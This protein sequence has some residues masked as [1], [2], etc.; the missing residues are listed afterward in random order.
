MQCAS[1]QFENMPGIEVCG[2]CGSPLG[3]QTLAIDVHPPRAG[4]RTKQWRRRWSPFRSLYYKARE[5]GRKRWLENVEAAVLHGIP[6]G[7]LIR[8][9]IPGWAH[10]HLG[11]RRR[12]LLFL[13]PWLGL[14][15]LSLFFIYVTLNTAPISRYGG[16]VTLR[17]FGN[18]REGLSLGGL[19][20]GLAFSVHFASCLSLA[21]LQGI[22]TGEFFRTIG[23][24]L[25]A[26]LAVLYSLF[27]MF[28]HYVASPI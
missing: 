22:Q 5:A 11:R 6:L 16:G 26:I 21:R 12:G 27:S 8:M 7:I 19:F 15:A 18:M 2:C 24:W 1:C 20:L 14:L 9:V 28:F 25:I 13:L 10:I 4:A 3:L 17:T 23:I